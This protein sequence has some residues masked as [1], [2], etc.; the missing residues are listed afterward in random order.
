MHMHRQQVQHICLKKPGI[1][2][3][4][5]TVLAYIAIVLFQKINLLYSQIS[6]SRVDLSPIRCL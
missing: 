3:F 6:K 5:I 2:I 4:E 1:L